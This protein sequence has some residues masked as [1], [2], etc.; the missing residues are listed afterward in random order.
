LSGKSVNATFVDSLARDGPKTRRIAFVGGRMRPLSP[1]GRQAGLLGLSEFPL[2]SIASRGS[3]FPGHP[4]SAIT[5]ERLYEGLSTV[6]V[7]V[8]GVFHWN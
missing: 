6:S 4:A 5:L 2:A 1:R 3:R 8:P 7:T